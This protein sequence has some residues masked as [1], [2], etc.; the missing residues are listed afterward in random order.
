MAACR[1]CQREAP[2]GAAFCA[3]CGAE[4]SP[5]SSAAADARVGAT[6]GGRYFL[7]AVLGRGGMGD[8]YRA[9]DVALDRQV[10]V[11]VLRHRTGD[12]GAA[13]RFLR[14]ARA[15]ARL[16][17]PG[18][19]ALLDTGETEGGTPFMA[20]ELAPGV[21]LARLLADAWP[22]GEARV[23]GIVA[24]VLSALAAAH[25][26]GI[27]H[28]DLKP[29]NVMVEPTAEGDRVKVLDFGIATQGEGDL[30]ARLTAHGAVFGTPAYM[31]PE[32]VRGDPLDARSDL[33]AVGVVLFELLCQRLPFDGPTPMAIAAQHLT[34][35]PPPLAGVRPG[36]TVTPALEE[37]VRWALQ[38]DPARRPASAEALREAL[39]ACRVE[40]APA[41]VPGGAALPETTALSSEAIAAAV[42][43]DPLPRARPRRGAGIAAVAALALAGAGG[44]G[45]ALLHR[46]AATPVTPHED[47]APTSRPPETPAPTA[48]GTPPATPPPA[49]VT[50][51]ATP[52]A[53]TTSP[54]PAPPVQPAVR[55][56][57]ADVP[58]REAAAPKSKSGKGGARGVD[59]RRP[60]VG[61][62][63]R[64]A[65]AAETARPEKPPAAPPS[66]P[67]AGERPAG[68]A[69]HAVRGELD[70]LPLPAANSGDG[71]LAVEAS[72]WAE[73][74]VDGVPLGETP[75]EVQLAAG[76]HRVRAVHP[77]LGAR[78]A[79]VTVRA[80]QRTL[81]VAAFEE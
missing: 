8:V 31:S 19:V 21:T 78:E 38:R 26:A 15:V 36:L 7:N 46:P 41:L 65:A 14:E 28:R 32:Q 50:P 64:P 9:T 2:A 72:P 12:A 44:G 66:P 11:K 42:A 58:P 25:A 22:L 56:A 68:P 47:V 54:P 77:D 13:E 81:W 45:W 60:S 53:E 43:T 23:V 34:G 49:A 70:S 5:G 75:R 62:A 57:A 39:L 69:V 20:M 71:L 18:I 1:E 33:Y 30:E 29:A 16:S 40:T 67:A 76:P 52:P 3:F 4:L 37:L 73:V 10:V 17:H 74:S 59:A 79:T 6:L 61:A 80:G 24:Q 63:T 51:P 27:V 55:T 35:A 48:A